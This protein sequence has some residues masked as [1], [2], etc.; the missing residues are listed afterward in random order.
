[1]SAD[2]IPSMRRSHRLRT[3]AGYRPQPPTSQQP[4]T[5]RTWT[6]SS[7]RMLRKS[8][9]SAP[10]GTSQLYAAS[11]LLKVQTVGTSH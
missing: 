9:P 6:S 2:I 8:C 3:A 5:A 1:M 7:T 4:S 11:S 10:K